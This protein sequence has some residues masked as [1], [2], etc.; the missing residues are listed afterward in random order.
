MKNQFFI[1]GIVLP[2]SKAILVLTAFFAFSFS[3]AQTHTPITKTV[4]TYIKGFWE[5]LPADYATS[6]KKYPLIIFMHGIGEVGNGS[7]DALQKIL[8]NGIP[9]LINNGTFP[10]TF[11]VN[12]KTE[13]FIVISPQISTTARNTAMIRNML[14]YCIANYRVDASRVYLT[15]LSQGGGTTWQFLFGNYYSKATGNVILGSRLAAAVP[16]CGN[17]PSSE[18]SAA[19]VAKTGLPVNIFH[20]NGDPTVAPANSIGWYNNLNAANISPRAMLTLYTANSHDAWTKTYDP[21]NKQNGLNIYEWML[22]YYRTSSTKVESVFTSSAPAPTN[23]AP[24]A[25]ISGNSSTTLPVDS[26]VLSGTGSKDNDGSIKSYS[27]KCTA[28]TSGYALSGATSSSLKVSKLSAGSYTF[29]LTVTD[30]KGASGTATKSVTVTAS[31]N[32]APKAV[33]N[34]VNSITLPTDSIEF[35]GGASYDTDGSIKTYR[36]DRVSG[37]ANH[38]VKG[39]GIS[40]FKITYLSEGSYVYQ[41]KVTDDKG[42]M[43]STTISF[44]VNAKPINVAPKAV[45]NGPSAITLPTDS[46]QFDGSSSY[47]VDGT[48]SAYRWDKVSGPS[49]QIVKG[50]NISKYKI[51]NLKAGNHVYKLKVT[52]NNGLTD[53][54]IFSFTVN[55]AAAATSSAVSASNDL[56]TAI[57]KGAKNITLP[58]NSLT[59][60]GSSSTDADGSIKSYYWMFISGPGGYAYTNPYSS[61]ITISNLAP[62]TRTWQLTVT[63]NDGNA[64][65]T[66]VTFT[67]SKESAA[68]A[69]TV[70][71]TVINATAPQQAGAAAA[72]SIN[73]AL[74][75]KALTVL[76]GLKLAPVPAVSNMT[77]TLNDEVTG[78]VTIAIMDASGR[79]VMMNSN[80]NKDGKVFQTTVNV[81]RLARG[82]YYC[83]VMVGAKKYD[84]KFVKVD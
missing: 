3:Q 21:N 45:V 29:Q 78:K 37:P 56:P 2:V 66:Q 33:I 54:T 71:D 26:V 1:K 79:T 6:T 68:A 25:A 4:D 27:W 30:D 65:S 13:S 41:L 38:T 15:G 12:G 19:T 82:A 42:A 36:W 57:V 62:G 16:I 5:Y 43:D 34:G 39:S 55:E 73:K 51:T 59:L 32:N 83:T 70:S 53:S 80:N 20:N 75:T 31:Q 81:S 69:K 28:G 17:Y 52:D 9:K 46:I 77:I 35:D 50:S 61:K 84:S 18:S 60:D 72:E 64:N 8:K 11:T 63:D 58:E 22:Q 40:K 7:Q 48:V 44:V 23:E 74:Y 67:V 14:D 76:P 49:G 24:V 10:K 47:D